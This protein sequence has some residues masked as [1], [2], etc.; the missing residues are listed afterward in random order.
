MVQE[1]M[2]HSSP[3]TTELYIRGKKNENAKAASEIMKK[4][5]F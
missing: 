2:G 3:K 5:M 1:C 4:I